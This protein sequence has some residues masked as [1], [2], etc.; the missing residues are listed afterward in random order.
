MCVVILFHLSQG[1]DEKTC[2][3]ALEVFNP[4]LYAPNCNRHADGNALHLTAIRGF[5]VLSK[6]IVTIG[7]HQLL[8]ER[9]YHVSR[10]DGKRISFHPAA[11]AVQAAQFS[12]A[13]VLL[14]AMEPRYSLCLH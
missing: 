5:A 10:V 14:Q 11:M 6:E 9:K 2:C 1:S 8:K 7:F 12:T 13:K 4:D 3:K